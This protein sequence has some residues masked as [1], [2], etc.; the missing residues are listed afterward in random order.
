[1][2]Q[3]GKVRECE[4]INQLDTGLCLRR[5]LEDLAQEEVTRVSHIKMKKTLPKLEI[6]GIRTFI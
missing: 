3:G 2:Q 4:G 5:V 6:S 1:M